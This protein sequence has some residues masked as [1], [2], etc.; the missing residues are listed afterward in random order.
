VTT[1]KLESKINLAAKAETL[2]NDPVMIAA[3]EHID[4]ELYRLFKSTSPTDTEALSQVSG[5]QYMHGKYAAFLKQC[6]V[7]GKLA[8]MD[9]EHRKKTLKERFF[10]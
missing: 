3:R 2:L 6:V 4:A 10:G 8:K 7:D 9:L 5:M 1:D